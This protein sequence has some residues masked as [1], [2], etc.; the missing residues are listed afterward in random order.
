MESDLLSR[1]L[2]TRVNPELRDTRDDDG[3]ISVSALTD[4][5]EL[6]PLDNVIVITV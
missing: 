4:L 6:D 3:E 1:W 2:G 5:E